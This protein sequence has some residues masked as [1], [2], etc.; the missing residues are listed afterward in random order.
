MNKNSLTSKEFHLRLVQGHELHS[1]SYR[2]YTAVHSMERQELVDALV[3][4]LSQIDPAVKFLDCS[5]PMAGNPVDIIASLSNHDL[6]LAS[7]LETLDVEALHKILA[8]REWALAN[9]SLF[10]H[11]FPHTLQMPSAPRMTPPPHPEER[12]GGVTLWNFLESMAPGIETFLNAL[13]FP[14]RLFTYQVLEGPQDVI[15]AV[16]PWRHSPSKKAVSTKEKECP[17]APRKKIE[18]T[19]KEID[20]FLQQQE[21]EEEEDEITQKE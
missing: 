7:V 17:S 20:D 4:H 13:S 21:G 11:L 5:F 1:P 12:C 10:G 18:L 16:V 19:Q 6:L 8:Q 9:F 2:L 15:L 3:A 14:L